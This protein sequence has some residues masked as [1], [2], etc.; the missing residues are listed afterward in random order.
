MVFTL[1]YLRLLSGKTLSSGK[2]NKTEDLLAF[3]ATLEELLQVYLE[4]A[5]S[6]I[7]VNSTPWRMASFY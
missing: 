4:I 6:G 1:R 2:V 7:H 5:R 3:K